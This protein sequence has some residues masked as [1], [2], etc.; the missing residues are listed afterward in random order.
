[1]ETS[2]CRY[3]VCQTASLPFQIPVAKN[4]I[5]RRVNF[6]ILSEIEGPQCN[7]LNTSDIFFFFFFLFLECKCVI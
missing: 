3:L 2:S 7:P 6:I 1:M 5:S 4:E